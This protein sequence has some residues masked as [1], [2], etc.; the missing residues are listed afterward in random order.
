MKKGLVDYI[1]ELS[2]KRDGEK[3]KRNVEEEKNE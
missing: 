1:V 3:T 2:G